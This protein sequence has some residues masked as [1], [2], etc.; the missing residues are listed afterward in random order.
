MVETG[1]PDPEPLKPADWTT[2][3][4]EKLLEVRMCDLG[5][6]I[7]GT[8]LEPRI[9]QPDAALPGRPSWNAR[10]CSKWKEAIRIPACASSGTKRVTRST[11]RISCSDGRP[12]DG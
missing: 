4:D 8:D 1:A 2:F 11:T 10:R 6:T 12:G 5:L 9:A 7:A 3:S